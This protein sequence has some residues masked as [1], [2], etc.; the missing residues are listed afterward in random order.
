MHADLDQFQA[1]VEVCRRPE[2]RGSPVVIGGTGDPRQPRTVVTCASYEART[3][4]V[5][6]GMSL[7]A[8]ARK[9]P[10]AVFLPLDH[11]AYLTASEQVMDVLRCALPVVVEVWGIDEAFL[12]ATVDDPEALARDIQR[13]VL[14]TTGLPSSVGIGQNKS[15]AKLASGF[16]KP[17]GI[18]RLDADNWTEVMAASR[19]RVVGCRSAYD[20]QPRRTRVVHRRRARRRRSRA[21][22]SAVRSGTGWLVA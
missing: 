22:G 18:Y 3:F 21:A 4:G 14:E 15:C 1:S 5:H 19:R 9:C 20:A 2:L 13:T 12:G 11:Q 17:A 7:R 10:D 16:A 6:A 8:A